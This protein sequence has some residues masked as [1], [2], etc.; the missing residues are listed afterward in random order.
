MLFKSI[1]ALIYS[2]ILYCTLYVF[3]YIKMF[4]RYHGL[5]LY[6]SKAIPLMKVRKSQLVMITA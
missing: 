3:D 6:I 2:V 4:I 5:H 1:V